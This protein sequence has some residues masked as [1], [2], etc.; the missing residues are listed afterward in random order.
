MRTLI[1]VFLLLN[2]VLVFGQ[3]NLVPNPSFEDYTS[4]P[5][6]AS[7]L[8]RATP[9]FNP[10]L[11]T[12]EYYNAC[13]TAGSYMSLPSGTSGHYQ[14]PRTGNGF[15]GIFTFRTDVT[16]MREYIEVELLEPLEADKCYYLEFF[17]NAPNNFPY[18]SD[19][20]GAH[21]SIGEITT[22]NANPLSVTPQIEHPSGVLI[23]DTVG[24]TK[25]SGYFIAEGGEDHLIIGNFKSDAE[26]N[27][28]EFNP[29]VW[30]QQSSYLYVD[31]VTLRI[32]EFEI[33][34]GSDTT[35]CEGESIELDAETE[36]A[37]YVWNDGS[38]QPTKLVTTEGEYSVEIRF[39]ECSDSDTI[40]VEFEPQPT[41]DLG[42]DITLCE[43]QEVILNANSNMNEILWNDGSSDSTLVVDQNGT[44][45]ATVSNEC[46]E[47]TDSVDLKIEECVCNVYIPNTFTPNN[48]GLNDEF[49]IGYICNFSKFEMQIFDRWGKMV[50][51]SSN[52]DF[53]WDGSNLPI[54]NYTYQL[55]YGST[56]V[57]TGKGLK[58]GSVKIVR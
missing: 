9:W 13:A 43:Q 34:L 32:H 47:A 31:D 56:D 58:V 51:Q 3:L 40:L 1:S 54:G 38:E 53:S 30:Y 17:V 52:P 27:W 41:I 22:T 45:W 29:G 35:L 28:T 39:G 8:E 55:W 12:P 48:D 4:C 20:I 33:E 5:T 42:E 25:V 10:N 7:Q 19:G 11:G 14:Y 2:S 36:D 16:S 49:S 26:T 15:A 50:F 46:G 23:T 21:V 18:A 24:W 6:F 57:Y 44:Y 37:E